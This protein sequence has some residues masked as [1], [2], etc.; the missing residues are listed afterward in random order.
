MGAA[1]PVEG[2]V[3][4][5]EAMMARVDSTPT[6]ATITVPTLVVVGDEDVLTPPAQA[7]LLHAG[8]AGSRLEV[9]EGSGHLPCL[10]RP[11]AFNLVV[12]EFLTRL[13]RD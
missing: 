3:A 12:G 4:G 7:Q 8:I 11:A 9:I 2:L 10:E 13:A 1:A 6:L 5:L